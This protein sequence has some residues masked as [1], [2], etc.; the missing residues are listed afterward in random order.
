MLFH[1]DSRCNW[2]LR[3]S[4]GSKSMISSGSQ[5]TRSS[6]ASFGNSLESFQAVV[7]GSSLW[8]LHS[9]S[10]HLGY[11]SALWTFYTHF[12]L[13]SV[14]ILWV[15]ATVASELAAVCIF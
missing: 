1:S 4:I 5:A 3:C 11:P 13:P 7:I 8:V 9:L 6:I 12:R 15:Q 14:S 2:T 10:V